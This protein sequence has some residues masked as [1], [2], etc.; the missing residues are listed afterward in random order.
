MTHFPSFLD[1]GRLRTDLDCTYEHD[2]YSDRVGVRLE[3]RTVTSSTD[4]RRPTVSNLRVHVSQK[5]EEDLIV[6]PSE[7]EPLKAYAEV[8][9]RVQIC[10]T[11]C[12]T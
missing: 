7:I 6:I 4:D 9:M 3:F 1:D 10:E 8:R 11:L 2:A 12:P 5:Q